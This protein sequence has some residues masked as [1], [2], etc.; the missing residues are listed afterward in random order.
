MVT[1]KRKDD[2]F[3][4][5]RKG[6]RFRDNVYFMRYPNGDLAATWDNLNVEV[7]SYGSAKERRALY[8]RHRKA[9][10]KNG[11]ASHRKAC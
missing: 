4:V 9:Q 7:T 6:H 8:A 5:G 11:A 10:E 2:F 3:V 1:I